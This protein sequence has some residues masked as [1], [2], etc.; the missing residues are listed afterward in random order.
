TLQNRVDELTQLAIGAQAPEIS[1]RNP[2]GDIVSL[3]DL[4]GKVVL[5]DFWASWCR[6]CREENPK[7]VRLY[8]RFQDKGFEILGV[9]LDDNKEAWVNAIRDDQLPWKQVSDLQGRNSIVGAKYQ[10]EGIPH[11]VLVDRE[12]KIIA[13]GLRGQALEQKIEEV[14]N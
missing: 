14:L 2:E 1:Q 7:I 5:I 10:V 13:K 6:P 9:S 4:R 3:S 11:T 8:N 12:G